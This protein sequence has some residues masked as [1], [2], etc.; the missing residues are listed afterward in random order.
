MNSGQSNARCGAVAATAMA[1][2][3]LASVARADINP[4]IKS[5]LYDPA[6]WDSAGPETS[7]PWLHPG[8]WTPN[9]NWGW[10]SG[11]SEAPNMT[12]SWGG[13]RDRLELRG[14]SFGAAYLGQL[15]SNPVG[16]EVEGGSSWIGDWNIGTFV[17]IGR[18]LETDQRTSFHASVD[19]HTRQYRPEPE[20][21]RKPAPGPAFVLKLAG[22]AV[23]AGSSG[24]RGT[25]VRQHR[26]NRRRSASCQRR[27]RQPS[28]SLRV[29]QPGH[30]RQPVCRSDGHQLSELSQRCLGRQAQISAGRDLVCAGRRL[31]RLSCP[32]SGVL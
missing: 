23:Q 14:I 22:P 11:N 30:L 6:K 8:T 1:L 4:W 24:G 28:V 7:T 12:G 31:S 20:I 9:Q 32:S 3:A 10:L 26:G 25:I 16:G 13:L 21:H 19:L 15:A 27:F 29:A 18:L 17:D 5:T 2:C